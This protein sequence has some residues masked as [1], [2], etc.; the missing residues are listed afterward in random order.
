[1]RRLTREESKQSTRRR[2]LDAG[3]EEFLRQGYAGAT[4]ETIADAAGYSKGAVYSN[5]SSKDELFLELLKSKVETDLS[6]LLSII[7]D[8]GD[9]AEVGD[10]LSELRTFLEAG[11]DVLDYMWVGGE[12]LSQAGRSESLRLDCAALYAQKRER[13]AELL[14]AFVAQAGRRPH[15][16]V[17]DLAAMM[18]SA[19]LGSAL[20]RGLDR[21][22]FPTA[23]WAAML[24]TIVEMALALSEED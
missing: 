5:F 21:E 18:V 4:L 17:E 16:G 1:M 12:F 14:R 2:L 8:K 3:Q 22:A 11:D 19:T 24:T 10:A 13:F 15:D 7:V 23:R 6:A 20:Q 9:D